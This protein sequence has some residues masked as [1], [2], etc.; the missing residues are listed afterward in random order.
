MKPV[1]TAII[2]CFNHGRFVAECIESLER[3]TLRQWRAI[4]VDD[5]STDGETPAL[6]DAVRS[7]RVTVVHL[8]ENRKAAAARNLAIEM[9][10]TEAILSLDADDALEPEHLATTVPLL[11]GDERCGIVYTDYRFFGNRTGVMYARPFDVKKLYVLQY[12]YSGSLFRKSAF[13]KTPRYRQAA[14]GNEDW[15]L[16]LSIVEAGYHGTYVRKPLYRHRKHAT[17]WSAQRLD[18]LADDILRSRELLRELHAEGLARTGQRARFDHD[19]WLRDATLRLGAGDVRRARASLLRAMRARPWSLE[20]LRLLVQALL[21]RAAAR[22]E[23]GPTAPM[24]GA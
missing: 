14:W 15:D 19:T 23:A 24:S 9:A 7:E 13:E 2:P 16:W 11:L 3:Q 4:V 5:A 12:I 8:P 20:P 1:V 21:P 10:D 17:Q 18:A 22:T 6:C